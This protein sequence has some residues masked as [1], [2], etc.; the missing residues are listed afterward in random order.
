MRRLPCILFLT[1]LSTPSWGAWAYSGQITLAHASGSADLSNYPAGILLSG[2]TFK[3]ASGG[4]IQH[5]ATVNGQVV[6]TDLIFTTNSSCASSSMKWEIESWDQSSGIVRA[7]VLFPT[8]SHT[9]GPVIYVCYGDST[10]TTFQGGAVGSAWVGYTGVYH[11]GTATSLS[12]LDSSSAGNNC[13]LPGTTHNP[14]Y[15]T[16]LIGGG[17]TFVAANAQY[18]TCGINGNYGL[19]GAT[20]IFVLESLINLDDPGSYYCDFVNGQLATCSMG[21][22]F[23]FQW[24]YNGNL[25]TGGTPAAG[26]WTHVAMAYNNAVEQVYQNGS[27]VGGAGSQSVAWG[28]TGNLYIGGLSNGNNLNGLLDESRVF[29]GSLPPAGYFATEYANLSAMTTFAVVSNIGPLSTGSVTLTPII[30]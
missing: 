22:Y 28:N 15:A 5:S 25:A 29:S 30:I 11:Y 13:T 19:N 12:I 23:A 8:Y 24:R 16:G 17:A 1:L 21:S 10:V 9:T 4:Q 27:P 18:L 2:T 14:T 7:W 20:S 3:P 26:G 6:P